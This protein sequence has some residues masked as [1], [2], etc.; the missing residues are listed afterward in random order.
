MM[1]FGGDL[2]SVYHAG[3]IALFFIGPR[4]SILPLGLAAFLAS[5]QIIPTF[6]LSR[7]GDRNTSENIVSIWELPQA[8]SC[9]AAVDGLLCRNFDKPTH[10]RMVYRFS[11]APWR[12]CEY[13]WPGIGGEQFP[14]NSRWL[15]MTPFSR[16]VWVPSLYSGVIPLILAASSFTLYRRHISMKNTTQIPVVF[17]S[18][19][20]LV[21]VLGSLGMFGIG[22]V[23]NSTISH[24][25]AML[26]SPSG[27]GN[28]VGGVY[29]LACLFLPGYSQFRYPAKLLTLAA[30]PLSLLAAEGF[31]RLLKDISYRRYCLRISVAI[32]VISVLVPAF[33]FA[34]P[35]WNWLT[36]GSGHCSLFGP[37]NAEIAKSKFAFAFIH[38]VIVV[39]VFVGIARVSKRALVLVVPLVAMDLFIANSFMIPTAGRD[40]FAFESPFLEIVKKNDSPVPPRIYRYAVWYPSSFRAKSSANRFAESVRFDIASLWPKYTNNEHISIVDYH[41]TLMLKSYA[42]RLRE[43]RSG[44]VG[45]ED[46]VSDIGVE[47]VVLPARKVLNPDKASLVLSVP[48]YDAAL[49]KL[50][51]TRPM[52][53]A[54]SDGIAVDVLSY[55]PGEIVFCTDFDLPQTI[56]VSEQYYPGW[57]AKIRTS[58]EHETKAD[59]F[60]VEE[61]FN[62]VNVPAGYCTI[63]MKFVPKTFY[64]GA[65]ISVFAWLLCFVINT[66]GKWKRNFNH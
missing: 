24:D 11:V 49:W 6:E 54:E 25:A 38:T 12:L 46:R 13:V 28:P 37:F 17:M 34:T 5:I 31:D 58:D 21:A 4:K 63:T 2:Q 1:I 53:W 23:F 22:W 19:M 27:V 8:R 7:F 64:F 15:S 47:Y 57:M 61:I 40:A 41:G 39:L 65:T 55:K 14:V 33:F 62:G 52:A 20:I 50:N 45:F 36:S 16:D 59:T 10:A 66:K 51:E 30:I 35:L 48:R 56:V 60:P 9:D 3:I 44:V 42:D 26:S 18:R 29:W 43:I 32:V